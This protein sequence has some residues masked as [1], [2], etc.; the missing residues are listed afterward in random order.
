MLSDIGIDQRYQALFLLRDYQRDL[1]VDLCDFML[2]QKSPKALDEP[3][4]RVEMGGSHSK[5]AFG[6]LVALVSHLVRCQWTTTLSQASPTFAKKYNKDKDAPKENLMTTRVDMSDIAIEYFTNR[7]FF[8]IVMSN[9][10]AVNE[11]SRGLAHVCYGN[12]QLSK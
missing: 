12:E 9:D 7:D 1:V 4:P 6:S 10:Y 11:Y 3:D 5:P 8:E 2:Q